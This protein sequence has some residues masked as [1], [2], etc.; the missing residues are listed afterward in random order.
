MADASEARKRK[1]RASWM[2][3]GATLENGSPC[4]TTACAGDRWKGEGRRCVAHGGGNQCAYRNEEGVRCQYL[5]RWDGNL[6]RFCDFHQVAKMN[7]E[8]CGVLVKYGLFK[9]NGS[10]CVQCR[11]KADAR[12]RELVARLKRNS[13]LRELYFEEVFKR[14]NYRCA[15]SVV[16]CYDVD[17]GAAMSV[18]PW[19]NREPL[20][21]ACELDHKVR[22]ADGGVDHPDNLQVL[23]RCC[24]GV[25]SASERRGV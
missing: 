10:K 19:G 21:D 1:E 2:V 24:H 3:C 7:C 13:K 5:A 6:G 17:T 4:P 9:R 15:Q 8:D 22:V 12:G 18:C 14:Q 20:R 16:A 11:V 25:K 23:C